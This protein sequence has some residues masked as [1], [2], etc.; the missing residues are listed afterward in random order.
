MKNIMKNINKKGRISF[1][2]S[3]LIVNITFMLMFVIHIT[4][5]GYNLH[6][7]KYPSV[8]VYKKNIKEMEF[9][10][11][12]KFCVRE[13]NNNSMRYQR[14]GYKNEH[15]FYKG[16]SMFNESILGWNGFTQTNT[17][18]GTVEGMTD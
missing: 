10:I 16:V 17:T 18:F 2:Q 7:P 8:H 14:I 4:T 1:L 13:I 5:I 3:T 12:F 6:F 15:H 9:P 11:S